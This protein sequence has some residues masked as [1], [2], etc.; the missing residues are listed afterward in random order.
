L[1]DKLICD[2]FVDYLDSGGFLLPYQSRFRKFRIVPTALTKI[3]DD[4]HLGVERSGFSIS[5]RLDFSISRLTP[6]RMICCC[7]S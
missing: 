4:I 1:V 7:I 2:Q 5:V 6:C 3:M